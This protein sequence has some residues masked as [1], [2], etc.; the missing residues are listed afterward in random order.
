M[1]EVTPDE[2]APSFERDIKP[3]FRGTDREAMTWAFDLWSYE[4]VQKN[5][6]AIAEVLESGSMPCDDG[7]P[8]DRVRLF[9]RWVETDT[10]P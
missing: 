1:N 4:D 10:Q 9:R 6:R 5:A 2:G 8:S 7:W 3:L